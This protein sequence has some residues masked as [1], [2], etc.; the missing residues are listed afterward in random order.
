MRTI[1]EDFR[2]DEMLAFEPTGAGEHLLLRIEK[3]NHNTEAV[4][5]HLARS[6]DVPRVAVS[7]AGRKDRHAVTAQWFSVHT[8]KNEIPPVPEHCRVLQHTRHIRKLRRGEID[9]NSFR[10]RLRAIEGDIDAFDA[11]LAELTKSGVPNYF[12]EQR[13]GRDGANVPR[14]RSY[15]IEDRR[16]RVSAFDKGLHISVARALVFNAVLAHRVQQGSWNRVIAGEIELDGAPTGPLWGRGR[17]HASECA[18]RI[19]AEALA[20]VEE[21]LSPLE[22]VGLAQERRT[23]VANP[24][25]FVGQREGDVV[26]L[27]FAL[28]AGQYATSVLRE[29]GDF[30]APVVESPSP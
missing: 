27:S 14:A 22:H 10:I 24:R 15:L 11:R 28:G 3:E 6:F 26:E 18:A 4:A 16:Q 19:E 23:L 9:S 5:Q 1:A 17:S 29:L 21:W 2:V 20:V 13:F 8:P 12:G 30:S 25:S 7:F